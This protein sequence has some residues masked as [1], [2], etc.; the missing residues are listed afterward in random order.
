MIVRDLYPGALKFGYDLSNLE[1][2]PLIEDGT[3]YSSTALIDKYDHTPFEFNGNSEEDSRVSLRAT[4]P[5]KIMALTYG[6]KD[7][8]RPTAKPK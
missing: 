5:C 7:T 8:Q 3:T 1:D 2:M 6:V 4:G